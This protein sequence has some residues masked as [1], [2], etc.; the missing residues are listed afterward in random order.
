MVRLVK[1]KE[2]CRP[3]NDPEMQLGEPVS[4]IDSRKT[5]VATMTRGVSR[6]KG[7]SLPMNKKVLAMK[8]IRKADM[9]RNAQEG[10]LRAERN[11]LVAAEGSRW[12]VPLVT[13]F[14]DTKHL[15][16]VM[17]FCIGGDFL[18]L[19]IRKNILSEQISK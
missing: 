4:Y 15:Y 11:F 9:I 5:S 17:N 8:V 2:V 1:D 6:F 18:G 14:Q 19:L 13:A 3:A 12:I 7:R 10:H 16:L